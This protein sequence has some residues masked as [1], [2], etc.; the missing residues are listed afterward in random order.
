LQRGKGDLKTRTKGNHPP[1]FGGFFC[2]GHGKKFFFIFAALTIK[3]IAMNT[4]ITEKDGKYIVSLEGELDTAHALEV[5]QAM[6]PLHELSGKDITID[7]AHLEYIASSGLRILLA[8]LKSAKSKGNK[9][10]LKNLNDE[11]KEVFKMT[12][13]IDLFD[14]E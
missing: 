14:I 9:V 10:V 11:I 1:N 12:G 13:F 4:N 3:I 2:F 7:C 6:Q 5:E 8:L